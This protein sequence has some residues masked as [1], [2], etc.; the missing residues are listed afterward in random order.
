MRKEFIA[1]I[2]IVVVLITAKLI[3]LFREE[4]NLNTILLVLE[5]TSILIL[6]ATIYFL[7]RQAKSTE[8]LVRIT[9]QPQISVGIM[10]PGKGIRVIK[11]GVMG[12]IEIGLEE[13]LKRTRLIIRSF[14]NFTAFVWTKIDLKIKDKNTD[15]YK[16][17][18]K[19]LKGSGFCSGKRFWEIDPHAIIELLI[20]DTSIIDLSNKLQGVVDDQI[21]LLPERAH[22]IIMDLADHPGELGVD[23]GFPLWQRSIG[24]MRNGTVT[25]IAASA[26]V[27]KSQI[28]AR[29]A[30][31]LSR[32]MPVLYCDSE[33]NE[34]AQSVRAYGMFS[35]INYEILETGYWKADQNKIIRDGY[36]RTFA[37]QCG[38]ARQS[39]EDEDMWDEFKSRKLYYK[40]MTG[41]TAREMIPFLRRW[42]MQHVG[43]DTQTRQARCLIVWDYIK[44]SRIEEVKSA[45][46]GAHD[47][48]GDTCMALHDFAEDFNLPILAFGQT[49]RSMDKDMSMIAGAKKIVELVDSIT[50][51]HK[52]DATDRVQ[53]PRGTHEFH[54]LG[55]RYGKGIST[56]I[57]IEA[58]LS[59]GKFKEL[60][61]AKFIPPT[62]AVATPSANPA[63]KKVS[64]K[65]P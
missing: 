37:T 32:F 38:L 53:A 54:D 10:S 6:A 48:L 43:V 31:E 5:F 3:F 34:T 9:S 41:M 52:K 55:S 30:I 11:A 46:V 58:D 57:D 4:L 64:V 7:Y 36:D 20:I 26:K 12:K 50:L 8:K 29:A 18:N 14:S 21:I 33:L 39:L 2:L 61:V 45:G 42:V 47:I 19:Y 65:K 22:D 28:G 16:D 60:G 15:K 23:I 13:N 24:G 59:I 35:E 63:V 17:A 62:P 27:G 51:F 40:K 1:L 49:N 56:H 44:L 25:F